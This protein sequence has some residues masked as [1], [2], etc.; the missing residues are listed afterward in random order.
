MSYQTS[1]PPTPD[2]FTDEV[3]TLTHER[4][5]QCWPKSISR[6]QLFASAGLGWAMFTL[7]FVACP[8]FDI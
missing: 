1:S 5:E 2:S 4:A 3:F 7:H 8:L 6:S